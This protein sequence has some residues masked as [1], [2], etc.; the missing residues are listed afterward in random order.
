MYY[1][2]DLFVNGRIKQSMWIVIK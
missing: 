1:H 2:D